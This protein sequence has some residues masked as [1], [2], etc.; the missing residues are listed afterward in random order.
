[1]SVKITYF[2]LRLQ[3]D[4]SEASGLMQKRHNSS[5]LAMKLCLFRI[6]PLNWTYSMDM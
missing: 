1:M 6:K 3:S 4:L 2:N 5:A